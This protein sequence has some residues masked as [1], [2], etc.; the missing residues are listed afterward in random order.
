L[1]LGGKGVRVGGPEGCRGSWVVLAWKGASAASLDA[2]RQVLHRLLPDAT[3]CQCPGAS[4][5][6]PIC[7]TRVWLLAG[8]TITPRTVTAIT[9]PGP[10]AAAMCSSQ[11]EGPAGWHRVG[12]CRCFLWVRGGREWVCECVQCTHRV[13]S[14]ARAAFHFTFHMYVLRSI[15]ACRTSENPSQPPLLQVTEQYTCQRFVPACMHSLLLF[16]CHCTSQTLLS[17][18]P[19]HRRFTFYSRFIHDL[20]MDV[21]DQECVYSNGRGVDMS[22]DMHRSGG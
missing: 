13:E 6:L 9:A 14:A 15:H 22:L 2:A 7:L 17:R 8:A 19:T 11:S 16:L 18:P 12:C 20:T 3:F 5:T 1:G 21:F 4:L 10:Q